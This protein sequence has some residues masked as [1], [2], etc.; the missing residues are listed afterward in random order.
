MQAL[1][2][3]RQ[4]RQAHG[5]SGRG[6]IAVLVVS[7]LPHETRLVEATLAVQI[8]DRA[9]GNDLLAKELCSRVLR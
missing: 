7:A 6:G 1:G 4:R 5:D 2:Q 8:G 3:A 9:Y